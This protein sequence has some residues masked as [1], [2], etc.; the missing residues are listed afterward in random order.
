MKQIK[1]FFAFLAFC[2]CLNYAY[3]QNTNDAHALVKQ[4]EQL[5]ADK[6]YNGAIEKF[7]EAVKL[8]TTYLFA[9]YQLA[10]ALF[11]AGRGAEGVPHLQKVIR[12]KTSLSAAA[13]D[14]LSLIYFRNRQ[15]AAAETNAIEAIKLDPKH[16]GSVR[17]YALVCFHQDKRAA[18]LMGFCSFIMLE[19]T[20][21][22]AAEA[23]GNIQHILQ[24]GALKPEA[25]ETAVHATGANTV[26]LNKIISQAIA[27]T[28]KRRYT[29]AG[30]LFTAQLKEIFTAA[31]QFEEKQSDDDFFRNYLAAYFY[32]L[33]ESN[34]IAAFARFISQNNAE[35]VGWIKQHPQ[36]MADLDA[37]IKATTRQF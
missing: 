5:N 11:L 23:Y 19:P 12:G 27:E 8:D 34:N 15:Y 37:W 30:D 24:G 20:T 7:T 2:G 4:G 17:T 18:A 6:N 13:Y 22:R 9:D 16:A 1:Y 31:G 32:Q 33:L 14:L 3:A 10:N 26:A 36:Q 28:E 35:S 25:G 29:S 21:L